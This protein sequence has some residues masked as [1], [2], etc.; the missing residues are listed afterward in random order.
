MRAIALTINSPSCERIWKSLESA[1]H[2]VSEIIVDVGG[3]SERHAIEVVRANAPDFAIFIG[4]PHRDLISLDSLRQIAA[5]TPFIHL[6]PDSGDDPWHPRLRTYADIFHLQVA[7]DGCDAPGCGI[8]TLELMDDREFSPLPWE[9]RDIRFAMSGSAGHSRRA[10]YVT[11]AQQRYGLQLF[12]GGAPYIEAA[13]IMCRFK[14]MFNH[15]MT[16]STMFDHCKCRT[17]EAGYAGCALFENVESPLHK[18][19]IPGVEF[20]TYSSVDDIGRLLALPDDVLAASAQA[21]HARV[22]RD[23]APRPTWD[24][25]LTRAGL[26]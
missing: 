1:G 24:R 12:K 14:I 13:R 26:M 5:L 18:W 17:I 9:S 22:M 15:S 23:Y 10:E 2:D 20:F 3:V 8:T 6:V 21:L 7:M 11:A 19:M 25:I 4:D 16:G